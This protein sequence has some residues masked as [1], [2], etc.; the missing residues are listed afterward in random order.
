[1]DM[2]D[3]LAALGSSSIGL[4]PMALS[5]VCLCTASVEKCSLHRVER[6]STT[7]ACTDF[8]NKVCK[9]KRIVRVRESRSGHSTEIGEDPEASESAADNVEQVSSLRK[10]VLPKHERRKGLDLYELTQLRVTGEDVRWDP[11]AQVAAWWRAKVVHKEVTG[12][13]LPMRHL[14]ADERALLRDFDANHFRSDESSRDDDQESAHDSLV[15]PGSQCESQAGTSIS[16]VTDD[17]RVTDTDSA[18]CME[19]ERSAFTLATS[20][21][22][23]EHDD[24]RFVPADL[25]LDSRLNLH[26]YAMLQLLQ[27]L[28]S[29]RPDEE[30][31]TKAQS[32]S[33]EA[34]GRAICRYASEAEQPAT[35]VWNSQAVREHMHEIVDWKRFSTWDPT[36]CFDCDVRTLVGYAVFAAAR[37]TSQDG[38]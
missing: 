14:N 23:D 11:Q 10:P 31:S 38:L 22:L 37:L 3:M 2:F 7:S 1:M 21:L 27:L 5:S 8:Q 4:D 25:L 32:L 20:F 13:R 26:I 9:F 15:D 29:M 6:E 36:G 28:D 17:D 18:E 35:E 19:R 16:G 34:I 30:Q 24:A 12:M 33:L